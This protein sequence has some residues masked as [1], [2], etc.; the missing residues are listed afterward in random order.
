MSPLEGLTTPPS[1]TPPP[2]TTSSGLWEATILYDVVANEDGAFVTIDG[3]H[4]HG[5]CPW[6]PRGTGRP[7][8]G[9]RCLIAFD[10]DSSPWIV[11][12]EGPVQGAGATFSTPVGNGSATSF[13]VTH[14]LGTRAVSPTV[15]DSSTFEVVQTRIEITSTNTITVYFD[16][17]PATNAF[18]VVVQAGGT[19]FVI[20]A[21]QTT[22][23]QSVK[24]SNSAN[25]TFSAGAI[26]THDTEEWD[27]GGLWNPAAPDRVTIQQSGRYLITA[28]AAM[29]T[30][31]SDRFY[32]Q[33]RKNGSALG[34][35]G[36]VIGYGEAGA[37]AGVLVPTLDVSVTDDLVAG[38]V[39]WF[40]TNHIAGA[41]RS[42]VGGP[43]RFLSVMQIVTGATAFNPAQ[44]TAFPSNPPD[45]ALFTYVADATLG[46]K[47]L[48]QYRAA[49]ASSYKWEFVGGSPL[50]AEVSGSDETTT[51]SSYTTLTTAGP[52]LTVPLAG[53]Y[54]VVIAANM[55]HNA[56][57]PTGIYMS[58]D[59][60]GTG[61]VDAD[62]VKGHNTGIASRNVYR[63]RRKNALA[64][65]TALV[66]KY[67]SSPGVTSWFN[68]RWMS[69]RPFRVSG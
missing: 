67:K 30:P 59:I 52:S 65:S 19:S 24:V 1:T 13:V 46:I 47:W 49:S 58:Y 51:S 20:E 56:G 55:Y 6:T 9:A 45:G 11:A 39:L 60:G 38:D 10:D 31:Y 2:A 57:V 44:G 34:S 32:G 25:Q 53:D 7:T 37:D 23:P 3:V 26:L 40:E 35:G 64:A 27:D 54:E 14:N 48:F 29:L 16:T 69:V 66:A 28:Q 63:A 61:A 17:A 68:D 62:G 50:T 41:N 12:W 15:Y 36:S 8:A 43:A 4:E 33:L 22:P 5:P 42:V 18:T 21:P